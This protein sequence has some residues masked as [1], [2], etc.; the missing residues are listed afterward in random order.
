MQAIVAEQ[1]I[2]E[3]GIG[4]LTSN[5]R[6]QR[7][8]ELSPLHMHKVA[9]WKSMFQVNENASDETIAICTFTFTHSSCTGVIGLA[10]QGFIFVKH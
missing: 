6:L 7:Q 3:A 8:S 4:G 9:E 1:Y 5:P 10:N 2:T